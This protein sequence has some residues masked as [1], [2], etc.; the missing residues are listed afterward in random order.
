[1]LLFFLL[2]FNF[3]KEKEIEKKILQVISDKNDMFAGIEK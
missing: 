1:M 2:V 3:L